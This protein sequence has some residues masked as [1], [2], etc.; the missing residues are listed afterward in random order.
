M[1]QKL[2]NRA[3]LII[4]C[5]FIS[6]QSRV[7]DEAVIG[8]LF[9]LIISCLSL[10]KRKNWLLPAALCG[11]LLL[12]LVRPAFLLVYPLVLYEVLTL[13]RKYPWKW[14]LFA[15][16]GMVLGIVIQGGQYPEQIR[17]ELLLFF[18]LAVWLNQNEYRFGK[19]E[20]R[21]IV[22]RN[23]STEME[24]ALRNKNQYL[25]EKQDSEI[26][27]ATLQE[28]NRIAREI[29][30]NV[31][32]MLSR[33][34]L[35]TGAM[36]AVTRE[37]E[38]RSGLADLKDCLDEAMTSIR[39][40]VHNLHDESIDL[41]QTVR[42]LTKDMTE[43]QMK[44]EYDM[45]DKIPREVKYCLISIVRE[46]LSNIIR[47]S[48]GDKIRISIVEHPAFYKL[49]LWDNGRC[50]EIPV[51]SEGIGLQNMRERLDVLS[52]TLNILS[53]REGFRLLVSIP[54]RKV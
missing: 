10:Y 50:Q 52:G 32:H 42:N 5:I 27:S 31:G 39:Q 53:G 11:Y 33:A 25:L 1:L 28:R 9:S 47:H 45:S 38:K 7:G 18:G 34:L 44:L 41:E 6:I 43:Y 51:Y 17:M 37:E 14:S 35:M 40:S 13:L 29:H 30:D 46:G 16:V 15:A 26:Y 54:K 49:E 23:D 8:L 48:S 3:V 24:L 4:C 36:L 21:Y 19:L 22:T 20:S 12:S 2:G